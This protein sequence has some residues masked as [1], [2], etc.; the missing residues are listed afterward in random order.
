MKCCNEHRSCTD[1]FSCS[2][3]P[4]CT[5]ALSHFLFEDARSQRKQWNIHILKA[6]MLNQM[7]AYNFLIWAIKSS[8]LCSVSST[9]SPLAALWFRHTKRK[10]LS[11]LNSD[12]KSTAFRILMHL[13]IDSVWVLLILDQSHIWIDLKIRNF[14]IYRCLLPYKWVSNHVFFHQATSCT[15]C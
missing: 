15:T 7:N 8:R 13:L 5:C 4:F 1:L 12:Q 10:R 11:R 14:V 6:V 2:R 9:V 3:D